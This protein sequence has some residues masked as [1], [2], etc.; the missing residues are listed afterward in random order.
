MH[1]GQVDARHGAAEHRARQHHQQRLRAHQPHHLPARRPGQP[2]QGQLP[3]AVAGAHHQGVGERDAGVRQRQ[4]QHQGAAQPGG[5]VADR[6][7]GRDPGV[8]GG[9]RRPVRPRRAVQPDVGAGPVGAGPQPYV[10][11]VGQGAGGVVRGHVQAVV[12]G[13]VPQDGGDREGRPGAVRADGLH[14][15]ADGVLLPLLGQHDAVVVEARHRARDHRQPG[16][17]RQRGRVGRPG[18]GADHGAVRFHHRE[19]GRGRRR[20]HHARHPA[21]RVQQAR[22]PAAPGGHDHVVGGALRPGLGRLR[23]AHR[24]QRARQGARHRD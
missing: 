3:A 24:L 10:D 14:R 5:P 7:R 18:L 1:P 22:D 6:V 13:A 12:P 19:G 21:Q 20:H 8:P 2:Q 11:P 23:G 9:H 4:A 15:P 16:D 17:H